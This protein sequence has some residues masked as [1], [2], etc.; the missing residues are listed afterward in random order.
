MPGV[1]GGGV[2]QDSRAMVSVHFSC[3]EFVL[4]GSMAQFITDFCQFLDN[5]LNRFHNYDY[6]VVV[7]IFTNIDTLI[8]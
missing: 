1:G 7:I 6:G 3:I 8:K 4:G 2:R 5:F